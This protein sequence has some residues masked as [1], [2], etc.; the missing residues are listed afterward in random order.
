MDYFN[1]KA[2]YQGLVA[3]NEK[4]SRILLYLKDLLN[5]YFKLKSQ[6][7]NT[8]KISF[9]SLLIEISKPISTN[10]EIKNLSGA[11]KIIKDFVHILDLSF[12]NEINQNNKLNSDIIQQ[13][14]D[15][16]K[17]INDKSY[18]VLSD[19]HKLMDKVY[20]QKKNLEEIKKL[21]FE[22]GKK[23]SILEEKLSLKFDTS[24]NNSSFN[25]VEISKNEDEDENRMAE[26]LK[27]IKKNFIQSE[28]YYKD[29]TFDI[30]T[31]SPILIERISN[32]LSSTI[33]S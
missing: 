25:M 13:I 32:K 17:F 4:N 28:K 18:I 3:Y 26:Q 10:Y 1:L 14:N 31:L 24:S 15:Y 22:Y 16:I 2:E 8:I 29:I 9:D 11:Q 6:A 30:N 27:M 21:Y 7:L 19:F 20:S 33:I 23:M 12:S 5:N